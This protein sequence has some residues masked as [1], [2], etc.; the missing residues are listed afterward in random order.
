M[1][2]PPFVKDSPRLSLFSGISE[3][4]SPS[5]VRFAAPNTGAPLTAP[6]RSEQR[7]LDEGK[8]PLETAGEQ[9]DHSG[10]ILAPF[11]TATVRPPS[12]RIA[13]DAAGADPGSPAPLDR[14]IEPEH[15]WSTRGE[16]GQQH[17]K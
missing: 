7:H 4:S 2:G 10:A 5:R 14:V 17:T 11:L 13:I 16:G 6:G 8:A 3:R 9:G 12:D 1:A 15:Q